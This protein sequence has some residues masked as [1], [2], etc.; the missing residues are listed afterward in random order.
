VLPE[1]VSF[2][3]T[4]PEAVYFGLLQEADIPTGRVEATFV[5]TPAAFAGR[6]APPVGRAVTS[7][8][9]EPTDNIDKSDLE[10]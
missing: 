10:S 5:S 3:L 9:A 6:T 7:K 8:V 1:R 4:E 2:H